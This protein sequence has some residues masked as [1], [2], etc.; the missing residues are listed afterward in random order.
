[1]MVV[2]GFGVISFRCVL[3]VWRGSV[4]DVVKLRQVLMGW[5]GKAWAGPKLLHV[6]RRALVAHLSREVHEED[7]LENDVGTCL[8]S[9]AIVWC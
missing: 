8:V 4:G 3:V 2:L 6:V 5:C 7:I 9:A 1:M